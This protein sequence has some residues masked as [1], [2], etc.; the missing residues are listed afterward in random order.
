MAD[1]EIKIGK[2]ETVKGQAPQTEQT[3][4]QKMEA[5][6]PSIQKQ[7]VNTALISAG[8]QILTQGIN[9]YADLTGNYAQAEAINNVLSIGSDLAILSTGPIGVIAV[10]S[11]TAISIT[12]SFIKQKRATDNI[13]LQRERAGFISKLGSRYG[14]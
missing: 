3:Q 11:K 10:A 5:G 8:K 6:R 7:A 13:K 1:I 12:N 4:A 2:S 9:Q 14:R